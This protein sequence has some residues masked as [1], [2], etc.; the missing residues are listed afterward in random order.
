MNTK[1]ASIWGQVDELEFVRQQQSP[2]HGVT[3][4]TAE[5]A[6]H[7][8]R[9]ISGSARLLARFPTA[10]IATQD[11]KLASDLNDRNAILFN[12]SSEMTK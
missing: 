2:R 3:F 10:E 1:S 4:E 11:E 8:P 6:I 9:P 7:Q 5:T 12:D